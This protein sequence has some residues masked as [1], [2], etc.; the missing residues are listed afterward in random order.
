MPSVRTDCPTIGDAAPVPWI[1]AIVASTVPPGGVVVVVE[2]FGVGTPAT[3]S[4]A[5]SAV[6]V[7]VAL[8]ATE[9]ALDG[10]GA[11]PVPANPVVTAPNATRS[12]IAGSAAHVP[13]QAS[14][15]PELTRAT[16]P[17][18]PLIG[19]V[20]TTSPVTAGAAVCAPCAS[21]TSR[22]P[23]AAIDVPAS[24]VTCQ[25]PPPAE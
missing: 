7:C 11:G 22:Y 24:D 10:A 5:L 8:R 3:K 13:P 6:F 2:P 19:I 12:T 4:A 25:V 18:V 20:P 21:A 16:F 14:A 23:P 1:A 17:A 15:P 9:F